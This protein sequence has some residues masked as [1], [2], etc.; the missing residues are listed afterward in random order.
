MH[1]SNLSNCN[2]FAEYV[3]K[4]VINDGKMLL[5]VEKQTFIIIHR[6]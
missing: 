3:L 1:T 4:Y 5:T 2:F 6:F